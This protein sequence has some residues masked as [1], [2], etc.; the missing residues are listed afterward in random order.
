VVA[1]LDEDV[2]AL[3]DAVG[4][5]TTMTE[6]D[7]TIHVIVFQ[8]ARTDREAGVRLDDQIEMGEMTESSI[9]ETA[10]TG[11][12][13]IESTTLILAQRALRNLGYGL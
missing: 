11:D 6:I 3:Q 12:L 7:T 4:T 1:V 13:S 10:T 9:E 5:F 8:S 2:A